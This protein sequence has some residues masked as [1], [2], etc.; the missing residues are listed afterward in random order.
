V[1]GAVSVADGSLVGAFVTALVVAATSWVVFA[2]GVQAVR[3]VAI[4]TMMIMGVTR[5]L[6]CMRK[7]PL[8]IANSHQD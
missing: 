2:A 1:G 8:L 7:I 5:D 4:M 6:T 3:R